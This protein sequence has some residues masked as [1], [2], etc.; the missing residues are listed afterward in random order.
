MNRYTRIRYEGKDIYLEEPLRQQE[1]HP[2]RV[3]VLDDGLTK[4]ELPEDACPICV[5]DLP[6]GARADY[7]DPAEREWDDPSMGGV[8]PQGLP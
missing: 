4:D 1:L 2:R 3:S 8:E 6:Q 7:L 5:D